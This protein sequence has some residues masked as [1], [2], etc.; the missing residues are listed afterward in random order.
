[1]DFFELDLPVHWYHPFFVYI[2]SIFTGKSTWDIA[3]K[4]ECAH[5]KNRESVTG[6]LTGGKQI[7]YNK[8]VR[9]AFARLF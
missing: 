1:M 7:C 9:R 6:Q 5:M 3:R 2:V 8:Y 4:D